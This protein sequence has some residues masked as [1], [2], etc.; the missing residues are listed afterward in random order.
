MAKQGV[1]PRRLAKCAAPTC[2]ACLFA[3][4]QR[5]PWRSKTAKNHELPEPPQRPGQIVSVDQLKSPTPGLIGQM[6]G[7]LTTKRYNYATV[8]VDHYSRLGYVHLQKTQ[9][10]METLEAKE[11]FE[12]FA[13]TH[14]AKVEN[15]HADNGIFRANKWMEHCQ[16][17]SQGMTFS[18]VGAHH[19]NGL[20]ERRI[21]E[22]QS[23]TRAS[24]IFA[25]HRW[26]EAITANLWPYAMRNA[27]ESINASP[28]MRDKSKRSPDQIFSG[29]LVSPNPKHFKPFGCP[30]Y[31]L[32]PALQAR[33]PYHKWKERARV[34]I[35]LGRSPRH[36][37]NVALVLSLTTGLVS[38]QFHVQYDSSFSTVKE[39]T[40]SSQ[41]QYRAGFV[42]QR[43]KTDDATS[44][45]T[46]TGI[47]KR[48]P[49]TASPPLLL[50]YL[51]LL[52]FRLLVP[53]VKLR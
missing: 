16:K 37:R 51:P 33:Q 47:A 24:L 44:T 32:D 52:Q 20:A 35:Y 43:E 45:S 41:W 21:K 1:I 30:V 19:T 23:M 36:P 8:F 49:S 15:Y 18:A 40:I 25:N 22:L 27:N 9:D 4:A 48:A 29:S 7:V 28:L 46:T 17:Q 42:I 34:G 2:S 6:T 12:R 26:K 31:V 50:V 11:A 53:A 3:K 10:V 38:P 39:N 13:A 5:K 14:G